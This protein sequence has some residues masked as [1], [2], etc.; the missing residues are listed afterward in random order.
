M[1]A[2]CL[3]AAMLAGCSEAPPGPA[4]VV[5]RFYE[6]RLEL[7]ISGAPSHKELQALKPLLAAE[8]HDLLDQARRRRDADRA[9]APAEK[10]AF[11]EGDLFSSLFEGPTSYQ[12]GVDEVTGEVHRVSVQL[13]YDLQQPVVSWTDKVVVVSEAGKWVVADVE[14]GGNWDFGNKGSLVSLLKQALAP[15]V[16]SGVLG[17]WVVT[18]HRIPGTSAMTAAQAQA[19]H[20]Q[21]IEYTAESARSGKDICPRATFKPRGEAA[22]PY[23]ATGF[24]VDPQKLG[25]RPDTPLQITEISCGGVD[26]ATL[27]GTL[28]VS[29]AGRTFAP[30]NGVFFELQRNQ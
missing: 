8:L 19:L 3:A 23:L 24:R 21:S 1:S 10:P 14:Y 5:G 28:F 12:V 18:G 6:L 7:D 22:G 25:L 17:K 11:A 29:P 4:D 20:G 2:A 13:A 16:A 27:G 9:E 15:R 30:W 26:W